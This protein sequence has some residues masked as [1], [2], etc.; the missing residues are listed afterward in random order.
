MK[1]IFDHIRDHMLSQL[2]VDVRI[3]PENFGAKGDDLEAI[4]GH[5]TN[6]GFLYEV[7][8]KGV[9]G[10]YRYGDNRDP[11]GKR[12][13]HL[14][15]IEREL[16]KFRASGN[17]EHLEE[18]AV[19]AMLETIKGPLG[20]GSLPAHMYHRMAQ[21]DVHGDPS[22]HAIELEGVAAHAKME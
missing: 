16:A 13:D 10:W 1:R 3:N 19:Y 17:T 8:M 21:D 6:W 22:M 5:Q 7:V 9:I 12:H 18:I 11:K 15:R 4:A 14:E 2:G 20:R